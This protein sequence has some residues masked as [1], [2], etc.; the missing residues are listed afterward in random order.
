[1]SYFRPYD[2]SKNKI[3]VELDLLNYATKSDLKN[4]T[5]VNTAHL[6]K[7]DDSANLKSGVDRL[8]IDKLENML[9]GLSSLEH[10]IVKLDIGKLEANLI[11]LSK[12]SDA[13]KNDVVK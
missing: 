4:A 7:K 10:K 3:A 1:M 13:V 12:L 5:G 11:D 9:S 8:V 6:D 2:H